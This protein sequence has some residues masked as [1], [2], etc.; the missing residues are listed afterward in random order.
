MHFNIASTSLIG[1]REENQDCYKYAE[2]S[3]GLLALVCDGMGGAKGGKEAAELAVNKIFREISHPVKES[4]IELITKAIEKA[5]HAIF[6]ESIKNSW[7]SEMGT[8][9]T[10]LLI[11]E[12]NAFTFH[13]GDSRIYHFREEKILYRTFDHSKVFEMVHLGLLSEEEARISPMSNII[14]KVLG[15]E[16]VVEVTCSPALTYNAGDRFLLC[17]DGIWGA[18]A[19][20]DLIKMASVKRP[21]NEIL[22]QL[23][24]YIETLGKKGGGRYD[25]MTAVLIE[26]DF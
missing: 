21:L 19:E 8:T 9:V 12:E 7:L 14:T 20:K 17:T 5:N 11:N 4:P 15:T 24:S 1:G 18:L 13:I 25:N 26:I 22:E 6:R 2:T 16:P 23:T 10:A 3:I